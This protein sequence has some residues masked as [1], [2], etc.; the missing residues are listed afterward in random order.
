[1]V[2]IAFISLV[3]RFEHLPQ[4]GFGHAAFALAF[5]PEQKIPRKRYEIMHELTTRRHA[6]V[7]N[8]RFAYDGRSIMYISHLNVGSSA[9]VRC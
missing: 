6:K 8:P 7:F 1:M 3:R 2:L 4:E 5:E 9:T